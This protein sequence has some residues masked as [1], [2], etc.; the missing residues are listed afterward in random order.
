V[1]ADHRV[2]RPLGHELVL[3]GDEG[4][5]GELGDLR[6][7]AAAEPLGRVQPRPDG[8]A[9]Q[10]QGEQARP[11]VLDLLGAGAELGGV[12]GP[13]LPHRQRHRVLQV[14]AADLD[15][16][17]PPAALRLDRGGQ[18]PGLRQQVIV[19]LLHGR[20]VHRRREAVVARLPH[21]DVV[22]RSDRALRPELAAEQLRGPVA[23][24]L[25]DVHVALGARSG[26]PHEQRV[27][28]VELPGDG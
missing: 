20:D 23:D 25:V 10:G 26:L 3:G 19:D 14:G 22:V 8:G 15:D 1:R 24:D 17:G 16:L 28:L 11:V 21:V 2:E 5:A 12:T 6:G 4:L 18:L 9:A 7:D 27:V 13:L